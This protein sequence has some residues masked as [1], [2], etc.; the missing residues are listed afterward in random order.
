MA[1]E[2]EALAA[3]PPLPPVSPAVGSLVGLAAR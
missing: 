3:L 2:L 1:D